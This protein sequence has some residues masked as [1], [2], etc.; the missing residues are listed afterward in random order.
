MVKYPFWW[1]HCRN[2][3]N[4]QRLSSPESARHSL[5]WGLPSWVNWPPPCLLRTLPRVIW[6]IVNKAY[7]LSRAEQI[8]EKQDW[9]WKEPTFQGLWAR[10]AVLSILLSDHLVWGGQLQIISRPVNIFQRRLFIKFNAQ[11]S[12]HVTLWHVTWH[13]HC[14]IHWVL[15]SGMVRDL[16]YCICIH[17]SYRW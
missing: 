5:R 7:K 15:R 8:I 12:V 4:I 1:T 10:M 11:S 3:I 14:D 17:W 6:R 16:L 9:V 13:C 2:T